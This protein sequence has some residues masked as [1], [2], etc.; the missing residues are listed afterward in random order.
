MINPRYANGNTR[1]KN[2]ARLKAMGCECGICNG[3]L[4]PIHYDE[5]SNY[6]YPLSFVVDEI[7]P[8]SRWKE[9]G[10]SS[11]KACAED[12]NNLQA[13]HYICNQMKSNKLMSEIHLEMAKK[14]KKI[15]VID[16]DW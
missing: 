16:G 11:A 2:R 8:V 6:E 10:Y 3:R 1:R 5:P 12:W 15:S 4:G 14:N 13:A 7:K 9:F